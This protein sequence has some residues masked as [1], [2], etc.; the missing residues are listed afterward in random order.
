MARNRRNSRRSRGA[1]RSKRSHSSFDVNKLIKPIIIVILGLIVFGIV[2][3]IIQPPPPG[4]PTNST[5][6]TSGTTT[7]SG[8]STNNSSNDA[9]SIAIIVGNVM[10]S[11]KIISL[12]DKVINELYGQ[13]NIEILSPCSGLNSFSFNFTAFEPKPGSTSVDKKEA[14]WTQSIS[15]DLLSQIQS[16]TPS[17]NHVDYYEAIKKV[18]N[19]DKVIVFGSGLNDTGILNFNDKKVKGWINDPSGTKANFPS[20]VNIQADIDWYGFG[21][22]SG[23]QSQPQQDS[24]MQYQDVYKKL[25]PSITFI[26]DYQTDNSSYDL[27]GT[28]VDDIELSTVA[29]SFIPIPGKMDSGKLPFKPCPNACNPA[30]FQNLASAKTLIQNEIYSQWTKAKDKTVVIEGWCSFCTKG[31]D[32]GSNRAQLVK[33]ILIDIGMSTNKIQTEN[34][35]GEQ[36]GSGNYNAGDKWMKIVYR[37]S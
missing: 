4:P 17:G 29:A 24:L 6:T 8:A 25:I 19:Y 5:Q 1:G 32:L 7:D 12:P 20:D 30:E 26:G 34:L 22:V 28:N 16:F 14:E 9:K 33:K 11:S 10:N 37:W 18:S 3:C 35:A 2:S 27:G 15:S 23:S 36:P 13:D 21:Q 31:S